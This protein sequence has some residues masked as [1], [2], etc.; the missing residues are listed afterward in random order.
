MGLFDNYNKIEKELL[1]IYSNDLA[2]VG[3]PDSRRM[4]K[5]LLNR[6]IEKSKKEGTYNLPPNFGD[7]ILKNE[8]VED[9]TIEKAAEIFRKT[10]HQ[11]RAE[12][13]KDEDIKW[14]WNL[15][16]VERHIMLSVDEMHRMALFINELEKSTALT[17]EMAANQASKIVWKHHPI[18]TY[19][20][21]TQKPQNAPLGIKKEDLPLPVELK[22]RVNIYIEKQG[23]DN[24]EKFKKE[25]ENSSTLNALI[26]KEIKAGNI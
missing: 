16:D 20:D 5:E 22:D 12:G 19:G 18:Y 8:R 21:P 4:A 10:L 24:P 13:V 6:A 11:K 25:V 14:W 15:N 3:I 1:E 17:K 9:P 2:T 26:R 7:I 23:R